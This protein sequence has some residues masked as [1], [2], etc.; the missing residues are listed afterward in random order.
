MLLFVPGTLPAAEDT[1]LVPSANKQID[2]DRDVRPILSERCWRCHGPE[3]QKSQLR[4]DSRSA[5]LKGG[6]SG[7]P[8]IIPGKSAESHLIRLVAGLDGK[9]IMPPTGERLTAEQIGLLRAWIDQ[10]AGWEGEA[11]SKPADEVKNLTT[12]HWSFQ[13]VKAVRLPADIDASITNPIDAFVKSK[14]KSAGLDSSPPADRV[15]L[16]RRLYLDMHGL[17]PTPEE[18]GPR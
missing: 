3:K 4:L 1:R 6:E 5:T 2:F 14:L 13:P 17:A 8:A 16:I 12:D 18:I 7:E 9:T 11:T 10:G 15:S